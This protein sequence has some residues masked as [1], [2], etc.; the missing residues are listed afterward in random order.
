MKVFLSIL[1]DGR[2]RKT[3]RFIESDQLRCM[4]TQH[5]NKKAARTEPRVLGH[6]FLAV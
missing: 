5:S 6:S 4:L 2:W 1:F 3:K